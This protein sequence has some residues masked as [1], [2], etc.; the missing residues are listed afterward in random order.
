M[1]F[2]L[3]TSYHYLSCLFIYNCFDFQSL[4]EFEYPEEYISSTIISWTLTS[5]DHEVANP[6][7]VAIE[8]LTSYSK[9]YVLGNLDTNSK[10]YMLKPKTGL[11]PK[12]VGFMGTSH[13]I[14]NSIVARFYKS[15]SA[16]TEHDLFCYFMLVSIVFALDDLFFCC[17]MLVTIVF[18]LGVM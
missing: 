7:V 10:K 16:R 8:I 2:T 1:M 12:L 13:D 5:M 4:V 14:I 3:P 9:Y 6:Q 15:S 17:F 18:T 11:G